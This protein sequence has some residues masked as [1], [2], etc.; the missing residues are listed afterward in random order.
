[1]EQR[2]KDAFGF[3]VYDFKL[4]VGTY[5]IEPVNDHSTLI[6]EMIKLKHP[7][8]GFYHPI[9]ERYEVDP[10]TKK[11]I[12]KI[13]H[14]KKPAHLYRMPPTHIIY[15]ESNKPLPEN[16]RQK[17]GALIIHLLAALYEGR[18]QFSNWFFDT[19]LPLKQDGIAIFNNNELE[20]VMNIA[21]NTFYTWKD[22]AQTLFINTLYI[23]S[24]CRPAYK[25]HWEQF[26]MEYIVTDSMWKFLTIIKPPKKYVR[27]ED[28]IEYMC[29]NFGL[30]YEHNEV[31][32]IVALRNDLFHEGLWDKA[33]PG[34]GGS[35]DAIYAMFNLRKLNQRLILAITGIVSNF[36]KS[37]WKSRN[38]Y[39]LL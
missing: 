36:I 4:K 37:D 28:R 18:A 26:L 9:E 8:D 12:K 2:L 15:S 17:E 34:Y 38:R 35:N 39:L 30:F 19:P 14:T 31:N 3:F 10:F 29:N 7:D 6:K 33:M 5:I 24:R 22:D 23:H 11:T 1:M 16:F 32:K 20:K 27:H 25:W 13:P 21:L